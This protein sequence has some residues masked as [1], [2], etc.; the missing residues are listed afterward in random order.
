MLKFNGLLNM[1]EDYNFSTPEDTWDVSGREAHFKDRRPG[2]PFF[3]VFNCTVTHESKIWAF[4]GWGSLMRKPSE[5]PAPSYYPQNNPVVQKDLA[6]L[7]TNIMM[8]DAKIGDLL[9]QLEEQNLMDSTIIVFWSDHGGPLP[10]QKRELY[11]SGIKVPLIIRFPEKMLAGTR[12]EK[13]VSLMDLGP[14][15]LAMAGIEKPEIMDGKVF[16]GSQS[17]ERKYIFAA[18]DRMDAQYELVRAISDGRYKY[19]RN[20]YPEKPNKQII[21]YRLQIPMMQAL[22][23]LNHEGNLS[24]EVAIWFKE[25]KSVEELYDTKTDPDEL[26]NLAADPAHGKKLEDMREVFL[27]WQKTKYDLGLI[28]EA[29]LFRLQEE[30][31]MPVY[32]YL[33]STPHYY[34]KIQEA[35][36]KSL[37]P[38][39]NQDVLLTTLRD[40]IPSVRFWAAKGLGNATQISPDVIAS[41]K[42]MKQDEIPVVRVAAA[43]ALIKAEAK[44]EGIAI[45]REVMQTAPAISRSFAANMAGSM[46]EESVALLNLL[47]EL[48]NDGDGYV[49]SAAKSALLAIERSRNK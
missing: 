35:A 10:R 1:K 41:L 28:P 16:M 30:Q 7:Y 23:K 39:G 11:N 3:S 44:N 20:Y 8:M 32:D 36:N 6:R 5:V 13:M 17:E 22:N 2:Q 4:G 38:D 43:Y 12:T 25:T 46:P 9:H 29:E 33:H 24:E 27:S 40:T 47:S 42:Q 21:Q 48:V 45:L 26:N 49:S 15:M 37:F 14:T 19:I 18:R 34:A 31:G